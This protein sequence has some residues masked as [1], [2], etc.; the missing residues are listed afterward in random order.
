VNSKKNVSRHP[1]GKTLFRGIGADALKLCVSRNFLFKV[2]RGE[3]TSVPLLKRYRQL[4]K[5]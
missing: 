4:K 3:A 1:R 2:L 5:L